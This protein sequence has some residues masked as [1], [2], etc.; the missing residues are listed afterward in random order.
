[1]QVNIDAD[2]RII[3]PADMRNAYNIDKKV[4][5]VGKGKRFEIWNPEDFESHSGSAKQFAKKHRSNLKVN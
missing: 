5:F 1:M 4:T 3:I 2:G